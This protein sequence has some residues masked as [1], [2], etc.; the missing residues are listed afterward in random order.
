LKV[1]FW[2]R[3]QSNG[4]YPLMAVNFTPASSVFGNIWSLV[5]TLFMRASRRSVWYLSYICVDLKTPGV[6]AAC[7]LHAPAKYPM[8]CLLGASFGQHR[9]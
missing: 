3:H 7:L 8:A 6:H 2:F 4:N 1:E 9:G 5:T